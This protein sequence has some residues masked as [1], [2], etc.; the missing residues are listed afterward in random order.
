MTL[1]NYHGV[2]SGS[3]PSVLGKGYKVRAAS[4]SAEPHLHMHTHPHPCPLLLYDQGTEISAGFIRWIGKNIT[5]PV[6]HAQKKNTGKGMGMGYSSTQCYC[7]GGFILLGGSFGVF[8]SATAAIQNQGKH[9][10]T[11]YIVSRD[12]KENF[13]A[14]CTW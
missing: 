9:R 10:K 11:V 13:F 12:Q 4:R 14:S 2:S 7:N 1:Q 3:N 5:L 8:G 6:G